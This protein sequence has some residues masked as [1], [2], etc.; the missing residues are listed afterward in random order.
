MKNKSLL[1]KKLLCLILCLVML[2][3][4]AGCGESRMVQ[5]QVFAMNTSMTLTAYGKKAEDGLRAAQG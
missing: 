3:P 4:L 2:L 5:S 1:H